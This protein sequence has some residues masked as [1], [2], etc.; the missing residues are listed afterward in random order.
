MASDEAFSLSVQHDAV[1]EEEEEGEGEDDDD[2]DE[3]LEEE[4]DVD[5]LCHDVL[6]RRPPCFGSLLKLVSLSGNVH[7]N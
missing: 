4:E 5:I 7:P 6:L 1:E 2:G 3:E